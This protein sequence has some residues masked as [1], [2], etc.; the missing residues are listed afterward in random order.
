MRS[1]GQQEVSQKRPRLLKN[2]FVSLSDPCL[3]AETPILW[4]FRT[5]FGG[6]WARFGLP[7]SPTTTFSTASV[8]YETLPAVLPN[9]CACSHLY[10]APLHVVV[11]SISFTSAKHAL[12]P[13]CSGFMHI[14]GYQ[15]PG[16]TLL[17]LSKK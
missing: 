17:K 15:F 11:G 1:E 9:A 16:I 4:F 3:E 5:C 14:P 12:R 7:T 6:V 10:S 13:G 8:V 2:P